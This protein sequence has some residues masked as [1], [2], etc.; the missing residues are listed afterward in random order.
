MA[1][2]F[3]QDLRAAV[4]RHEFKYGG[5]IPYLLRPWNALDI[6]QSKNLA[7]LGIEI[8]LPEDVANSEK[9]EG[10]MRGW[11]RSRSV[12]QYVAR[13]VED[14]DAVAPGGKVYIYEQEGEPS[15]YN[16]PMIWEAFIRIK[17]PTTAL[18][19][20]GSRGS[21]MI[22][23]QRYQDAA[24]DLYYAEMMVDRLGLT[25]ANVRKKTQEDRDLARNVLG[26]VFSSFGFILSVLGQEA[27][28]R[29][30][31]ER[32][33]AFNP[34]QKFASHNL[35]NVLRTLGEPNRL[36]AKYYRRELRVNPSHPTAGEALASLTA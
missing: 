28:A 1:L 27:E 7:K 3:E 13:Y 15:T 12:G 4:H 31:F 33:L 32:A 36:V 6:M 23:E 5:G 11:L 24:N 21:A 35:G 29:V 18:L 17:K 8:K 30:R 14:L 16:H 9:G 2:E 26:E 22:H 34:N 20:H 10:Q 25:P 19:E